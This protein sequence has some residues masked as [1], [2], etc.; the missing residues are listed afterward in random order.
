MKA[1][2]A[3]RTAKDPQLYAAI[4][5]SGS[6]HHVRLVSKSTG[7]VV[8]TLGAVVPAPKDSAE[9]I[10]QL[11]RDR[12]VY[13]LASDPKQWGS[14]HVLPNYRLRMDV[15][16]PRGVTR[17][18]YVTELMTSPDGKRVATIVASPDGD[19]DGKGLLALRVADV[20]STATRT[21]L[22]AELQY[23]EGGPDIPDAEPN[24]LFWLP[25]G[26]L[27]GEVKCCDGGEAWTVATDR[28][29]PSFGN[30]VLV[31]AVKNQT[32]HRPDSIIGYRGDEVLALKED[33]GGETGTTGETDSTVRWM[34]KGVL[35]DVVAKQ[36][37]KPLDVNAL[38]ARVGAYPVERLEPKYPYRGPGTVVAT[39]S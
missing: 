21:L 31:P 35:G 34:R 25:N 2:V 12:T 10:V 28:Q 23:F 39:D 38:L 17:R 20:G 7:Q 32:E 37:G 4:T 22:S 30:G 5:K 11:G 16:T 14:A 26:D 3:P 33:F 27:V 6:T 36:A 8:Q 1:P 9:R 24:L 13:V 15:F 18:P 19:G 29:T